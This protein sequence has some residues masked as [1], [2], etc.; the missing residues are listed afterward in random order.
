MSSIDLLL[1]GLIIEKPQSAY[2]LA[3]S[4]EK[5]HLNSI[6]KISQPAVYKNCKKLFKNDMLEGI[7]QKDSD[8]PEKINYTVTK[9]GKSFF[10]E[11][12]KGFSN[13]MKPFY[14]EHNAFIWSLE[15]LNYEEGLQMLVNLQKS[16]EESK[17]WITNHEAI[18]AE[19]GDFGTKA[20][21]K[22]YRMII[23][24]MAQWIAETITDYKEGINY[25]TKFSEN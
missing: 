14:F 5:K 18:V 7:A 12:M 13:E 20:L 1:L 10:Y 6:L 8:L 25:D 23:S 17:D 22:Q 2:E 15:K 24:I 3:N 19:T 9:K 16:I 4:I 21:V 11:L